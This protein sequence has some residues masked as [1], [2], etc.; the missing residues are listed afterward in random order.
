[1]NNDFT[2]AS[3]NNFW[4]VVDTVRIPD[5]L[6]IVR[7]EI[8]IE[9]GLRLFAGS[10]LD[11]LIDQSPWVLNLGSEPSALQCLSLPDFSSSSVVFELSQY[12]DETTFLTHLQS[13]LLANIE[14]HPCLLRFY[15]SAFWQPIKNQLN[16]ADL[17]TLLG[18]TTSVVWR[19]NANQ[20]QQII[21]REMQKVL[22]ATP[23]VLTSDIFKSWV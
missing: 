23:Y 11:Y 2:F 21:Q 9:Q 1:M 7:K 18:P 4:L 3:N 8:S 22:P 15:T 19:D 12:C 13:V 5:A 17:N 10:D 20:Q 14:S 16:E 6:D